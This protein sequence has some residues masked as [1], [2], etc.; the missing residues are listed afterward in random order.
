[1]QACADGHK[2]TRVGCVQKRKGIWGA[3]R[4][5]CSAPWALPRPAG[6]TG[7]NP[8]V[9]LHFSPFLCLAIPGLFLES[10]IY[11]C[12]H[13]LAG[14]WG[15]GAGKVLGI[16]R[17]GHRWVSV[18]ASAGPWGLCPWPALM[19]SPPPSCRHRGPGQRG[20][21]IHCFGFSEGRVLS[22]G[23]EQEVTC[24]TAHWLFLRDNGVPG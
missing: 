13:C 18:V 1:M 16:R 15:W 24:G 17:G 14:G 9:A 3:W 11:F 23:A 8:A 6:L 22:P 2:Y 7:L 10:C 5:S 21:H 4:L 12:S 20:R 19:A